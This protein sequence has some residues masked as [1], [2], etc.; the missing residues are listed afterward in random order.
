[1][2]TPIASEL[3]KALGISAY[4]NLGDGHFK[5]IGN[6]PAWL[7]DLK[8]E[9]QSHQHPV[10]LSE[11]FPFL[12]CFWD[13]I[14]AQDATMKHQLLKSGL[15]AELT[16]EGNT[17]YLEASSLWVDSKQLLLITNQGDETNDKV[18]LLQK[19]R[20]NALSHL[21]DRK[22]N[23][24]ELINSTFYDALTGL[25]NQTYFFLQLT[26]T[27]ESCRQD[28]TCNS[29][30]LTITIDQF[31]VLTS[32]L[33]YA[34]SEQLLV[35]FAWRIR[36]RLNSD[37][38]LA[39]WDSHEFALLLPNIADFQ[40]AHHLAHQLLIALK[41]PYHLNNQEVFVSV[42]IGLAHSRP[43]HTQ[44]EDLVR[45]AHTAMEQAL[46]LGGSQLMI[47]EPFMHEQAVKRCQ[48]KNDLHQAIG[49]QE[50]QV[51]YQPVLAAD[52]AEIAG[53][54]AFVRWFHPQRGS[55]AP[56][57]FLPVAESIGLMSAVDLWLMREACFRIQ[58]WK[59]KTQARLLVSVNLSVDQFSHPH[60]T[61]QIEQILKETNINPH[62]LQLEFHEQGLL[63]G[64]EQSQLRLENLKKL[65][66][67]L[68]IDDFSAS[69]AALN[70]LPY[71]PIDTLKLE[72]S[73]LSSLEQNKP[74]YCAV[75]GTVV[76]LAHD[77]GIQVSAKGVENRQQL[78]TL[79][80]LG[81]DEAQGYFF[82]GPLNGTRATQMLYERYS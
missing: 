4:E 59:K 20:E 52:S 57:S 21:S 38:I 65:G 47:F 43:E 71:L 8:P 41:S 37:R 16:R 7:I 61:D 77:L 67:Q 45:D 18:A 51:H 25:P 5:L 62:N 27:F 2:S 73:C 44:A 68:C 32:N 72:P 70:S 63:N 9:L 33:G 34:V 76:Q 80:A 28:R 15:W 42:N 22:R 1:M 69:S 19:A 17:I 58:Q 29:A 23:S 75:I 24:Q 50:L 79:A 35:E 46:A 81:C 31:H 30:I 3:L 13:E 36:K 49:D 39:R 40:Q 14:K 53:F 11:F 48:L 55:I 74:Q 66:V 6:L 12:E 78:E 26:Q 10:A 64:L 60:L 54:E 56:L 82:A